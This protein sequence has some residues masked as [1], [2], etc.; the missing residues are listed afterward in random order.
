MFIEKANDT[1]AIPCVDVRLFIERCSV[2][3]LRLL[4]ARAGVESPNNRRISKDASAAAAVRNAVRID[5]RTVRTPERVAKLAGADRARNA[6][7]SI[8]DDRVG[9]CL[10]IHNSTL[11]HHV[12]SRPVI[13]QCT[14]RTTENVSV[15][16]M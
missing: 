5:G 1:K 6:I 11:E 8:N 13:H 2:A 12:F 9:M 15:A 10:Q 4:I 16:P 3:A 7:R 14:V